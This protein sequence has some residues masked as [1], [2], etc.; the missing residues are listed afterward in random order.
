MD[1]T[2]APNH[3]SSWYSR[4]VEKHKKYMDAYFACDIKVKNDKKIIQFIEENIH[5]MQSR[6]NLFQ[7]DDFHPGN[8]IVQD[9][10]FAGVIDFNR[11]DWGDPYHEFLKIGIFTRHV[12]VPFSI[13]QIRGYFD[14]N[15]PDEYFWR[16]YSLYMAMCVF[17]TVIWTIKAIPDQVDDMLEKV[18]TF[19]DDHDYFEKLKPNWYIDQFS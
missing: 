9:N 12:S 10:A 7:H 8:I 19:L 11:Y 1:V 13:G 6:P 16:L 15:D 18:Y 2:S 14:N 17:S 3:I 4:K 5:H